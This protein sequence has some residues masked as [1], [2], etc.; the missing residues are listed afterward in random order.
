MQTTCSWAIVFHDAI[1][2][3]DPIVAE[4]K[5]R[6]AEAAIFSRIQGF[7]ATANSSEEQALFHALAT[8]RSLK[9]LRRLSRVILQG[10]S[11]AEVSTKLRQVNT[12]NLNLDVAVGA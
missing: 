9:S 2:E 4:V 7:S 5:I 8:I 6:R 1:H 11:Y 12:R 10:V 3:A